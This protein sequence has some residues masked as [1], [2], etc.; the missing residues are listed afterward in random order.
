MSQRPHSLTVL[1]L[2]CLVPFLARSQSTMEFQS[3]TNI[4]VTTGADICADTVTING[5]VSGAGTKCNGPLPITLASFTVQANPHGPGMLLEW[6]TVSEIDNL[7]FYVQC[8]LASDQSF[9][10]VPNSFVP[11]HGTT[12]EPHQYSYTHR[13][14]VAGKYKY[15]LKQVD[16]DGT[17]HYWEPT[18]DASGE[19]LAEEKPTEFSISQNYP[20]PFNPSTIIRYGLPVNAKVSLVVYSAVG[21]RVLTLIEGEQEAGYH[22]VSFDGSRLASGV[23]FYCIKAGDFVATTRL[24]LLK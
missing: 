20:N 11:G 7:G 5:T 15:R 22:E 17:V 10:E 18:K 1:A 24:I 19:S 14:G 6:M 21:Q 16:L 12:I 13:L 4:E 2:L 9:Q 8:R 3:G 23:Y